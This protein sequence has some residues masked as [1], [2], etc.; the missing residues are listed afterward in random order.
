VPNSEIVSRRTVRFV[1]T[2][3]SRLY[4]AGIQERRK[5]R[6][7]RWSPPTVFGV[8]VA[9]GVAILTFSPDQ[10]H[11]LEGLP[12]ETKLIGFPLLALILY[13]AISFVR[14]LWNL[15]RE[16]WIR[17]RCAPRLADDFLRSIASYEAIRAENDVL[18]RNVAELQVY[19]SVGRTVLVIYSQEKGLPLAETAP[20]PSLPDHSSPSSDP[21]EPDH[22]R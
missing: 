7:W 5:A 21:Q 12:F 10:R 4:A 9:L 15:S 19:A 1:A 18:R 3:D 6:F 11:Q 14:C 2:K 20:L 16:A 22:E 13:V 8:V 17:F